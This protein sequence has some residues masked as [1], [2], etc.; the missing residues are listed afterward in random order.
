MNT[1][2]FQRF[3]RMLA[4]DI[5]TNRQRIIKQVIA[6]SIVLLAIALFVTHAFSLVDYQD[7][8]V[9]VAQLEQVVALSSF[10]FFLVV[11]VAPSLI[12]N[13][14]NQNRQIRLSFL[15]VPSS[16]VEKYVS[17]IITTFVTYVLTYI[18]AFFIADLAQ[19]L[20]SLILHPSQKMFMS[21]LLFDFGLLARHNYNPGY[22]TFFE[23]YMMMAFNIW[24]I[25]L[26]MLGG[27]LFRRYAW[28]FVSVVVIMGVIFAVSLMKEMGVLYNWDWHFTKEQI[29]TTVSGVCT[30]FAILNIFLSFRLFKR[31]Q[32]INNKWLNL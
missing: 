19:W 17:R 30:V 27:T 12:F 1:F 16:N 21:E 8:T 23:W 7:E 3:T 22:T 26:Y 29:C 9:F 5:A 6:F 13:G 18:A 14:V 11:S 32:L 20:I 25:S 10:F 4:W 2:N 28:L 31:L 15:M 24:L